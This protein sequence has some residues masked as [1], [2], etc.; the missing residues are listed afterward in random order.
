ME[1]VTGIDSAVFIYLLE[2]HPQY[3]L[4]AEHI[5]KAVERGPSQ[6]VLAGIGM[7]E[8]LTGP[9]K[10]GRFDIANYY[11]Y[12]LS[13]FP[14]LTIVTM[15]GQMAELASD[16][17]AAY[18]IKAMDAIHIATA[19]VFGADTFITNDKQLQKVKEIS[20]KLL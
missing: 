9:K 16:L 15:N 12:Y 2:R 1:Q 4:K 18:S 17:C 6:A 13:S 7:V 20:V 14:H 11:R 5:L 10:R 8:I 3:F 19:I